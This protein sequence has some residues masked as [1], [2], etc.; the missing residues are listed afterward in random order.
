MRGAEA[1]VILAHE[2][3]QND[4]TNSVYA[5]SD[6]GELDGTGERV[7]LMLQPR[8]TCSWVGNIPFRFIDSIQ[9]VG[10]GSTTHLYNDYDAIRDR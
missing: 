10:S 1:D 8:H 6:T 7:A 9:L 5:T 2:E 3:P 4:N